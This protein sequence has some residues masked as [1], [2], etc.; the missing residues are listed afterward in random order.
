MQRLQLLQ[1]HLCTNL[2]A[3][4]EEAPADP[5]L[6]TTLACSRDTNPRKIDLGVGT[7][8]TDEGQPFVFTAVREA[9]RRIL[10]NHTKEYLPIDGL[11]RFN[12]LV[13]DLLFG[14]DSL[15][16]AEGRVASI[17]TISGT[18][19]LRVGAEFLS[20]NLRI[21]AVYVPRPTWDN[22]FGLFGRAGL[23]VREYPYWNAETK[24]VDF[25]GLMNALRNAA[26]GSVIVL[27]G[28]AHNPTGIDP[29]PE[30]WRSIADVMESRD[31]IPYFDVAYQGFATGDLAADAW[32]LRYFVSRGF[33]LLASQSFEKNFGLYGEPIGALHVVCQDAPTAAKV[34]SQVKLVI[35][36]LYS[37]PS[38]HAALIVSSILGDVQL[39]QQWEKELKTLAGRIQ[40]IRTQLIAEL[41]GLPA[42]CSILSKQ[43]GMFSYTGLNPT[44]CHKLISKW[45]CYLLLNGRV[46]LAGLNSS[47]LKYFAQALLDVAGK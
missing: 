27:H 34:V 45:H 31:L 42:Y 47:N 44:Q 36:P 21:P 5:I 25:A 16:V 46:S 24:D 43:V 37:S 40:G 1:S 8:R 11:E 26:T 28:C 7:Y 20:A 39:R 29:T 4:L 23:F 9:E 38:L 35:R 33:N 18:G 10:G 15:A 17:Q 2:F 19:S 3:H 12:T 6:G 30:Q 32:S 13:R 14:A 22:H 41:Q